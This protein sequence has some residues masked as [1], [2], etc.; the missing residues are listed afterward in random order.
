MGELSAVP[1]NPS[2]LQAQ[3]DLRR[4]YDDDWFSDEESSSTDD[5]NDVCTSKHILLEQEKCHLG[6]KFE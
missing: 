6:T 5:E 2:V 3:R 4:E 1:G